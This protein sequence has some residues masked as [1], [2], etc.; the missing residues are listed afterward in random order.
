MIKVKVIYVFIRFWHISVL[1]SVS[2]DRYKHPISGKDGK[3][4]KKSQSDWPCGN[5]AKITP[6]NFKMEAVKIFAFQV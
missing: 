4:R 3:I 2:V 6:N 1:I 5:A